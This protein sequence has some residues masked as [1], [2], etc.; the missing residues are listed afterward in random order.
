MGTDVLTGSLRE[1]IPSFL[2]FGLICL[3]VKI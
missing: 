1:S 2:H 3:A